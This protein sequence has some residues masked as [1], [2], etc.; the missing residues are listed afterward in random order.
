MYKVWD[1]SSKLE[2]DIWEVT[3][4][5]FIGF[6]EDPTILFSFDESPVNW[7]VIDLSDGDGEWLHVLNK[8]TEEPLFICLKQE[9]GD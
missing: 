4:T 6:V 1:V 3:G 9:E 5:K 7:Q 2:K 8:E